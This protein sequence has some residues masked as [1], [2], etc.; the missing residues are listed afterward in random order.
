[1]LFTQD[2]YA[3]HGKYTA[4]DHYTFVWGD[5]RMALPLGLGTHHSPGIDGDLI[6]IGALFNHSSSPNVNYIK[7]K[8]LNCIEYWTSRAIEK[9]E[10]LCIFYGHTLWFIDSA[11]RQNGLVESLNGASDDGFTALAGIDL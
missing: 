3:R 11:A 9:G 7:R 10:E 1:L 2:E 5:G 6:Y 8:N 4:V